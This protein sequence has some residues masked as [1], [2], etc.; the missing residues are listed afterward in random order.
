MDRKTI[1]GLA[2]IGGVGLL[3]WLRKTAAATETA[4]ASGLLSG[5]ANASGWASSPIVIN[6][7]T[8]PNAVADAVAKAPPV[9]AP[10][11]APAPVAQ[12]WEATPAA[13]PVEWDAT[14]N[15]WV[16]SNGKPVA[17]G[18]AFAHL[19]PEQRKGRTDAEMIKGLY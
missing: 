7:T 5:A 11:P 3:L 14:R 2:A 1:M 18:Y 12:P 17:A 16:Q 10:A 6:T 4:G 9:A 15:A 19:T 13:G 8:K